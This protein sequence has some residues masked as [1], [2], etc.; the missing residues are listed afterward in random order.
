M[1][2]LIVKQV[3][4]ILQD[5]KQELVLDLLSTLEA[6]RQRAQ[7]GERP[8]RRL[9]LHSQHQQSELL[10]SLYKSCFNFLSETH[11]INILYLMLSK[12]MK[13]N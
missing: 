11:K 10:I 6:F 1:T 8:D 9:R 2:H 7:T 3:G 4:D 12:E 5:I 13:M